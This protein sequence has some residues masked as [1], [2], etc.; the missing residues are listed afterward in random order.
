MRTRRLFLIAIVALGL[1]PGHLIRSDVPPPDLSAA[2][3]LEALSYSDAADGP[4][5]LAGLWQL[6]SENDGFG[7]YSAMVTLDELTFLAGSDAG[8]VLLLTRPDRD[9]PDPVVAGFKG[10]SN[11]DWIR[12]DLEALT[13]DPKTGE[14]WAGIEGSNHLVRFNS[15]RTWAA[16][17]KQPAM[18]DWAHNL[19]AESIVRLGDGRLVVIAEEDRGGGTH[20]ALVFSGDPVSGAEPIQFTVAG[21]AGYNPSE[22]TLLPDGRV[23]VVLRAFEL[24]LPPYFTAKL[25][26]FEPQEIESGATVSLDEIADLASP[27]PQENFEGAVVTEEAGGDWAIWLISDDNFSQFQRTLILRLDWSQAARSQADARQ[28]ARR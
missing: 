3:T 21:Q 13:R 25:A 8:R 27:F 11:D 2:V 14:F 15:D 7:G 16:A 9:G 4:L 28:K 17:I 6:T 23:L 10:F 19:G 20:E 1:A 22:A 12:I 5:K 26:V 24:G 18:K